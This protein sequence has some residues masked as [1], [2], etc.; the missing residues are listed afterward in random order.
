M[1]NRASLA[2]RQEAVMSS[3]KPF[4]TGSV[5]GVGLGRFLFAAGALTALS[6]PSLAGPEGQK[7]VAGSAKF[8]RN[9]STT[10]ITASNNSIINYSSF[11]IGRNETVRFIQPG[12][13]ARV[14]NR[15]SGGATT[16]NGALQANGIVYILNPAGV[17][18][19]GHALVNTAGLV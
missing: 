5:V 3:G 8:A 12:A 11:N 14:L 9:G 7:V 18:F 16:I 1:G 2:G 17:F 4:F 19:G 10:T 13:T 6:A 15:V